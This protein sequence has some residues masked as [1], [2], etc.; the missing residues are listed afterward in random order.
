MKNKENKES[1]VDKEHKEKKESSNNKKIHSKNNNKTNKEDKKQN[2]DNNK[3]NQDKNPNADSNKLNQDN[4]NKSNK[5]DKNQNADSNKLNQSDKKN[6][7]LKQNN[8]SSKKINNEKN[9]IKNGDTHISENKNV[10]IQKNKNKTDE[11]L[12]DVI[13]ESN[14]EDDIIH[15]ANTKKSEIKEN[16]EKKNDEKK[17]PKKKKEKGKL[18]MEYELKLKEYKE[19]EDELNLREDKIKFKEEKLD[20]LNN[21]L[22]KD[23]K[24]LDKEKESLNNLITKKE[25]EIKEKENSL[26]QREEKL[27]RIK[28]YYFPPNTPPILIGLENIGATCYMN[29]SL[30]CLSNTKKFTKFF[31]CDYD[32]KKD[33]KKLMANEYYKLLKKLWNKENNNKPIKPTS[34]KEILSKQNSLFAGVAANDSKDFINFLIEKLHEELN[35]PKL[36]KDNN[37]INNEININNIN[38]G[39]EMDMLKLFLSDFQTKFNSIISILFY[40]I[41]ET[42]YHCN[43]CQDIKF[44]FQIYSFIEFHLQQVNTY[45]YNMGK[46]PLLINGNINPNIDLYECFDYLSKIDLMSG[47]NQMY[48]NKCN[49][50][51]DALYSTKLYSGPIYLIIY[52]NRGKGAVYECKVNFPEQL[53]LFNY[54]G[55]KDGPIVYDLYSVVCHLGPSSMSGHFVAYCKNRSDN[56]WYL[57]ND[58]IVSLCTK[59]QQY[60][61]GMPYILFYQAI[62]NNS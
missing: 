46:R 37:N 9:E 21:K 28:E 62:S 49:K 2:Q 42:K 17:K 23:I 24:K 38:Y 60:N 47:Q 19:K 53:N 27:K 20:N 3:L 56:K 10:E 35:E 48:C 40:G 50:E 51:C 26:K 8:I 25:Q 6:D 22:K 34:F 55:F 44:N 13:K 31:L 4:K 58:A 14:D 41:L 61:D 45:F 29:A 11:K 5:D 7:G 12:K 39:N 1:K 59:S 15:K 33:D 32:Y 57:Y 43:V 52:L 54:L 18:R 36:N 16:N 30:Q